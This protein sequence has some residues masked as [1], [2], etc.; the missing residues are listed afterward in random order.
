MSSVIKINA[1]VYSRIG[2]GRTKNTNSFYLNGKYTSQQYVD[3]L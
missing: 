3:N 1:S 2:Y